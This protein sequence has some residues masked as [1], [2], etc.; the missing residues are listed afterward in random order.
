MYL[1]CT[2]CPDIVYQNFEANKVSMEDVKSIK[3]LNL[4]QKF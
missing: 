1:S 2:N 4:I 3:V